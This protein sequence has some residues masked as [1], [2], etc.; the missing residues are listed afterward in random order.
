MP[1]GDNQSNNNQTTPP[2]TDVMPPVVMEDT[3]PPILGASDLPVANPQP[4]IPTVTQL[5]ND[6][7]VEDTGSAA[8]SDD[9]VMPPVITGTTPK[10]KFAGGRVIATI[11]GLFLL[12]G[13]LGAG[14]ILTQQDQNLE[15]KAATNA[16]SLCLKNVGD[17]S[18]CYPSPCGGGNDGGIIKPPEQCECGR[19]SPGGPC[20]TCECVPDCSGG[21]NCGNDGCG[22][23]CGSCSGNAICGGGGPGICGIASATDMGKACNG[24]SDCGFGTVCKGSSP[25]TATCVNVSTIQIPSNVTK[26]DAETPGVPESIG[27]CCS[28]GGTSYDYE[29]GQPW[30]GTHWTTCASGYTCQQ[31]YGCV[32]PSGGGG[33]TPPPG[34]NPTPTPP[35]ITASCQNLRAYSTTGGTDTPL[36]SAQ[37]SALKSG[38]QFNLCVQG[39]KTGGSFDKVRFTINGVLQPE[40]AMIDRIGTTTEGKFC[41][42]YTIPQTLPANKTFT[43]RA[44]MHHVTL[45]WK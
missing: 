30:P 45:G 34:D 40:Q 20:K 32:P 11:L 35:S 26:C 7:K 31:D 33:G 6:T 19:V 23:S 16:C 24:P 15:E 10:K 4:S 42:V 44:E 38:D 43:F 28:T 8:P 1:K 29:T 9:V 5:P 18:E 41:T 39:Q 37:L 3:T 13:G 36:T 12:V 22:G 17:P 25:T 27:V 21:K 2:S 14:L